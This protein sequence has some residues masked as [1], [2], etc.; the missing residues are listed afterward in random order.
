[1]GGIP[2][3]RAYPWWCWIDRGPPQKAVSTQ[4]RLKSTAR[5]H[6]ADCARGGASRKKLKNQPEDHYK[7]TDT[8]AGASP[9]QGWF[10]SRDKL[11]VDIIG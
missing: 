11:V 6:L 8:T 9:R 1:L 5:N 4:A 7:M 3:V 10:P 2:I